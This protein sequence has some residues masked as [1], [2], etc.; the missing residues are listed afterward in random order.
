MFV[1]CFANIMAMA[2]EARAKRALLMVIMI[3]LTA[4][5]VA[6]VLNWVLITVIGG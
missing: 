4:I 1:P 2:K 6:G 5:F 3:N